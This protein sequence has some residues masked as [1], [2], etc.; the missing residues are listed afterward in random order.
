[1]EN[2]RLQMIRQMAVAYLNNI[3]AR[4][5]QLLQELTTIRR[6]I[7]LCEVAL[8]E[9]YKVENKEQESHSV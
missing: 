2:E 6:E 1:M 5:G 4:E 9:D 7:E 3:K 8:Q